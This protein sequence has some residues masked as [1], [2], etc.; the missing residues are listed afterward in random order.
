VKKQMAIEAGLIDNMT[1]YAVEI[2]SYGFQLTSTILGYLVTNYAVTLAG[3]TVLGLIL[4]SIKKNMPSGT[5]VTS[6]LKI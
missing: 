1:Q 5:S 3:I 4:F 2:V 6:A